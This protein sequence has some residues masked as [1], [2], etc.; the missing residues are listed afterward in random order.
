MVLLPGM[1]AC[2]MDCLCEWS[3][4]VK[5]DPCAKKP[6]EYTYCCCHCSQNTSKKSA[7]TCEAP[8]TGPGYTELSLPGFDLPPPSLLQWPPLVSTPPHALRHQD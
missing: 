4:N 1:P 2:D 6:S 5:G 3:S 7:N 8:H